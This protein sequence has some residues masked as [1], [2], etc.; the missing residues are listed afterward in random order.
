[1]ILMHFLKTLGGLSLLV[2]LFAHCDKPENPDFN[3]VN[4]PGENGF[5]LLSQYNFFTGDLTELNAN[6]EARVLPYD[7]NTALFSDYALKKRFVYVPEGSVIP[8]D[9]ASVLDLPLGSALIKHFYYENADGTDNHIETRLLI[10]QPDGWQ[11]ETYAWNESQTDAQRTLVGG[12][13]NLSQ[14]INGTIQNF[15]YLIPNQNQCKNCHAYE[16]KLHPIGPQVQNLNK[17]YEYNFGTANQIGTWVDRSILA[18]T[19]LASIPQWPTLDQSSA[20]LD[21]RA[22]AYLA[23]NCASCHR[24]EGSAANSGLYLEYWNDEELSRGIWK[25]PVAAGNGSGGLTYVIHPGEADQSI[26]LYRMISDEVDERMP[27]IGRELVH[28]EGIA[29]IREWINSL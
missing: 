9:T 11:A 14:S 25:T 8:F 3:A 22:R 5:E 24:R 6:T 29:L 4:I 17:D 27:E 21:E 19:S 1:M 26:L 12:T 28:E 10:R 23:V 20:S 15:N 13:K 2:L 18:N 16:G 7:L